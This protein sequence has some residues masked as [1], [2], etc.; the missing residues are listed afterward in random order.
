MTNLSS[1]DYEI[2]SK[3]SIDSPDFETLPAEVQ[4]KFNNLSM[5]VNVFRMLGRSV[6]TFIPK[7]NLTNAIFKNLTIS[8]YHKELVVLLVA[9]HDSV[10][11]E[12]EQHVVIAQAAGVRQDQFIA[13]AEDRLDDEGAFKE[14]E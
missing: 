12:W 1:R 10:T 11:Y 2:S 9:A 5:K 4:E 14:D 8:D 3:V 13:I 7:I 6:G